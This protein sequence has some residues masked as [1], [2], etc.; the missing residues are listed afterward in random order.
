MKGK[1]CLHKKAK[2]YLKHLLISKDNDL[3]YEVKCNDCGAFV[4]DKKPKMY[5]LPKDFNIIPQ[6]KIYSKG[7]D[8]YE[9]LNYTIETYYKKIS[10]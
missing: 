8:I 10:K 2:A 5:S 7:Q 1:K 3:R 6:I 4:A 9:L